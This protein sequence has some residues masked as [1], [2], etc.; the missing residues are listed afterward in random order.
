MTTGRTALCQK[1]QERGN[2]VDNYLHISNLPLAWKQM[3]GIIAYSLNEF[4]V[5]NDALPVEQKGCRRKR[6][7]TKDQLLID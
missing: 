1:D 4:F 3:S 5:E 7:G 6:R 2:A